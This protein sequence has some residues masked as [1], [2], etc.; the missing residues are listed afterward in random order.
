MR[1]WTA[2][3]GGAALAAAAF[4]AYPHVCAW[5]DRDVG[6]LV[7]GQ[8]S[9]GSDALDAWL[10]GRSATVNARRVTLLSDAGAVELSFDELGLTLD[11]E[12]SVQTA[13]Q[14]ARTPTLLSRLHSELAPE[15]AID[16]APLAFHF[17]AQRAS[18]RLAEFA[19]A[20]HREP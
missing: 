8:T 17:D 14:A 7:G 3:V 15:P 18:A 19:A 13:R 4:G 20:V 16:D 10:A 5:R 1:V 12:R 6:I 11:V 9:P 2:F